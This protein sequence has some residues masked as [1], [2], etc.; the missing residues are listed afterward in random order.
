MAVGNVLST[1]LTEKGWGVVHSTKYN[2][3]SYNEA[4]ATSSK[5]IKSILSKY[6][7][8]KIS[9]DLH[10]DGQS[11]KTEQAKKIAHDKY[12]TEINGEKFAKFF[13]VVGQRNANV[14]ELKRQAEGITSLAEKKYPGLVC[15]VVTKQYG[16]FNQYIA[17]NG[18][19]IEIGNNATS[20]KEAEATCKYVAEILD[21]YYS[22]F[23]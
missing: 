1:E 16:R 21:E 20:T 3:L 6:D 17:D 19:L 15:P 7:S 22:E 2:D 10:R 23:K 13:L 18:L 9:I 14:G 4:Y 11:L 8:V 12:T 5:T